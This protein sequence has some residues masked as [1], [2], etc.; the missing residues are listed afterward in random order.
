MIYRK[1]THKDVTDSK[2]LEIWTEVLD[3]T[4]KLYPHYFETCTPEIYMDNSYAHLGLCS[5]S[6][7]NPRERN[8]DRIRCSRCIITIS[9]N[10]Q[11]DY[12]QI[13]KTICHELGHFVSPKEN[14]GYLW[15]VRANRIGARWQIAATR[16]T[17]NETFNNASAQ[18]KASKGMVNKY[19]LYC[20]ECGA[21]WKYKTNC[22]AV[23]RPERYR[24]SKC[25]TTLKSEKI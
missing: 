25:K 11:N 12:Q 21:E 7:Q 23:Q 20:P 9:T 14:H 3:E 19:R 8:V 10:L 1:R 24:C 15:Q 16:T 22:Q 6:F 18:M 17:N 2:I 5:Q 13:R 4:R